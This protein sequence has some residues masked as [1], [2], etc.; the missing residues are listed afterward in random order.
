MVNGKSHTTS[1]T[2]RLAVRLHEPV[3]TAQV[4]RVVEQSVDSPVEVGAVRIHLG[5]IVGA[6]DRRLVDIVC[7]SDGVLDMDRW[8]VKWLQTETNPGRN[9]FIV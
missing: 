2:F 8:Y 4:E 5:T 7:S 9:K 6:P 1:V 3:Q